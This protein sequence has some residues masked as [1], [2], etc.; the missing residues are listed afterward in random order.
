[1]WIPKDK[2]HLYS[3]LVILQSQQALPH[4]WIT[5]QNK[6]HPYLT[7]VNSETQNL[8]LFNFNNEVTDEIWRFR[9]NKNH[10]FGHLDYDSM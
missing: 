5:L 8:Q 3:S 4:D 2:V 7:P 6:N 9:N 1:M 10:D